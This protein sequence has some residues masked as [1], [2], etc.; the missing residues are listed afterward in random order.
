MRVYARMSIKLTYPNQ[1]FEEAVRIAKKS[2]MRHKHGCVIVYDNK[3]IISRGY[4][5]VIIT[6]NSTFISIHAEVSA[7]KRLNSKYKNREILDKCALYVVR[8]GTSNTLKLS[9]PCMNCTRFI[10]SAKI[11]RIHFSLDHETVGLIY[12]PRPN[13]IDQI[14]TNYTEIPNT[15]FN[16]CAR[17][18]Y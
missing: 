1:F 12:A 9:I 18:M 6:S 17:R 11:P 3:D 8:I 13:G 10:Y 15:F 4:N 16:T 5:S 2:T 7:I 14:T